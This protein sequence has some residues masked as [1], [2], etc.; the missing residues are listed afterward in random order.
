VGVVGSLYESHTGEVA[1]C[2]A[3]NYDVGYGCLNR[4]ARA[5]M[6]SAT[7]RPRPDQRVSRTETMNEYFDGLQSTPIYKSCLTSFCAIAKM[8]HEVSTRVAS[9]YLE[10]SNEELDVR[11]KSA[12]PHK[13]RSFAN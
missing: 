4:K 8:V 3:L 2:P 6:F 13:R 5:S 11:H 7:L 12:K 9:Q 1:E 10:L